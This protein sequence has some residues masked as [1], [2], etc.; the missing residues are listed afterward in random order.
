M[1]KTKQ[2][3]LQTI[4]F[5]LMI[6]IAIFALS[7]VNAWASE[8][9][10]YGDF[11]YC[12]NEEYE[13]IEILKYKGKA[14]TVKIP[15][16][17][18]GIPVKVIGYRSFSKNR[19]GKKT[20]TL[21]KVMIPDSVELIKEYAF[22]YCVALNSVN[23]PENLQKIEEDIFSD[24][25]SLKT[26]KIPENLEVLSAGC[27]GNTGL[28]ELFIPKNIRKIEDSAFDGCK[29][30]KKITFEKNSKLESIGMQ[31]F[32]A[33]ESLTSI[34]FPASIEILETEAFRF[35]DKLKKVTFEKDSKLKK[36][37]F[38]CFEYCDNLAT[39]VIP[40]NV[41]SIDKYT[42]QYCNK[43][44]TVTFKGS[45]P[46]I[47]TGAFSGVNPDLKFKVPKKYKSK[48][49]KLLKGKKWYKDTM[50]IVAQ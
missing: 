31:A 23:L 27:F 5:L 25:E 7:P 19:L 26:I 18:E 41:K 11:K 49:T 1:K 13:G 35:C 39:I 42:F 17:I 43:L 9:K 46:K 32:I 21:K 33:C 50:K 44:K 20:K 45:A 16:S 48:Y 6:V 37:E 2:H 40:R 47:R 22:A 8:T 15:D 14:E 4:C 34:K 30:L 28:R 3:Y 29:N 24:C 12:Y 36:I 38:G 10:T